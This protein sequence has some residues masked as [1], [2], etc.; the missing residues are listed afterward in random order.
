MS[1]GEIIANLEHDQYVGLTDLLEAELEYYTQC[2]DILEEVKASWPAGY[3][4]LF[5]YGVY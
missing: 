3:V 1:R 5:G 4:C 2:K